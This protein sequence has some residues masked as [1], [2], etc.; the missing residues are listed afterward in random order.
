MASKEAGMVTALRGRLFE[1]RAEDGR[2]VLCEVRQK[3]KSEAKNTT[4]VAAGDDVLFVRGRGD[5][6]VIE[7]VTERRS[8]FFRPMVGLEHNKQV[9]AANLDRLAV[10][11]SVVSPPLKPGLID[12]CIIAAY[13]GSMEP[14]IIIN[15]LD[16]APEEGFEAIVNAYRQAGFI[17]L[18]VSA[19]TG[20]GV[21]ALRKELVGHRTLFVGH[22]GVGKSTLLNR[23]IPGLSIR[24]RE[25]STYSNKGKHTTTSVE[26]YELPSGGFVVDSPGLKLMGLWEVEKEELAYYYPEFERFQD[27]CRFTPCSH[28]HE[29]DCAVQEAVTAG[30]IS[31]IRY[32]NYVSIYHS[33]T[34]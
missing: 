2:H 23:L 18:E 31:K 13:N 26:F 19:T 33:L 25:V 4:P 20:E 32:D 5:R 34:A 16:L 15:K 3:V 11:A 12:R 7:E 29:P 10:V 30:E 28:V 9:I 27:Q 14:L 17:I 24:T 8:A 21:D 1:V 22:S 6:G